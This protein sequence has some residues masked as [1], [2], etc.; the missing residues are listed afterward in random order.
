MAILE[1]RQKECTAVESPLPLIVEKDSPVEL[2][3]G[4]YNLRCEFLPIFSRLAPVA[5]V[6]RHIV[7]S[8]IPMSRADSVEA[9][10]EYRTEIEP[11]HIPAVDQGEDARL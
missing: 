8:S 6:D 5:S 10:L 7:H 11:F 4:S 2:R 3:Q 9:E 1:L